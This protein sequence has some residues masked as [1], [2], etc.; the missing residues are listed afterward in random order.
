MTYLANPMRPKPSVLV[1][2]AEIAVQLK[3]YVDDKTIDS[4]VAV[5]HLTRV[6]VVNWLEAMEVGGFI[7]NRRTANDLR[8]AV[9]TRKKKSQAWA[10]GE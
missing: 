1:A 2:L 7:A 5:G 8:E 10:R 9:A 4:V 6:E 3:Q